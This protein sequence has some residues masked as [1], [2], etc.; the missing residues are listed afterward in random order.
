[1]SILDMFRSAPTPAPAAPAVAAPDPSQQPAPAGNIQDP[2][3]IAANSNVDTGLPAAPDAGSADKPT[4][5]SPLAEFATIWDTNPNKDEPAAPAPLN[6]D[7]VAKIVAKTDF[8]SAITPDQL[9]A[10]TAGGEG[11]TQAFA[12]A[13]NSVAQQVM[14]QS[15]MVSNKLAEQSIATAVEAEVAKMPAL[16][17]SQSA[18]S[19]LKDANPLFSNPAVQPVMQAAQTQLLQKF[20]NATPAEI[21]Q[22]TQDYVV[23]MGAAFRPQET[24]NNNAVGEVDWESFLTG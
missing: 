8:S 15:T 24:V 11:A 19:H 2:A 6:Q 4:A 21:T 3:T 20:P 22:M 1:M 9:A 13:M 5:D 17:R 10:I 14:V 18:A 7:A 23:A 12:E 16:M